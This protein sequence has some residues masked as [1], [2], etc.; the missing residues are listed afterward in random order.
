MKRFILMFIIILLA[1]LLLPGCTRVGSSMNGSGNI[2]DNELKV[3]GFSS[4]NINGP[5]VVEIAQAEVFQVTLSTDENL[6]NRIKVSQE[7]NTLNLSIE[8]P[9]TF[10]PTSLKLKVNMPELA[11]ISLSGAANAVVNGFMGAEM[12][13]AF[14]SGKSI[15]SCATEVE[16]LDLHISES[17]EAIIKGKAQTTNIDARS[18]SKLDLA[19]FETTI[20]RVKMTE[21]SEATLNVIGRIDITLDKA[22][23]F[24]YIGNP[25][26]KDTVISGGSSMVRK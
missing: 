23:I 11:S 19:E 9:A 4:V 10:F 5:F 14:L 26:F 21:A 22:S 2:I 12:F 8:A 25:L 18:A 13:T 17:S 20:A 7:H 24:Y 16:T 6:V 1:A 3:E 15:L